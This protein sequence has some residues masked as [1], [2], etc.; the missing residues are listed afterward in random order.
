VFFSNFIFLVYISI[1]NNSSFLSCLTSIC[2]FVYKLK[3]TYS[4]LL[5][6]FLLTLAF[7]NASKEKKVTLLINQIWC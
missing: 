5:S 3:A 2:N 4:K 7:S 6:S 1:L